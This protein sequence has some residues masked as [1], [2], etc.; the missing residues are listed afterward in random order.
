MANTPHPSVRL[1]AIAR[2]CDGW[3]WLGEAEHWKTLRSL[4]SQLAASLGVPSGMRLEFGVA[5]SPVT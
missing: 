2:H 4:S 3:K 5:H 1:I